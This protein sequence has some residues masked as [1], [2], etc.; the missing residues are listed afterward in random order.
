M[1]L[2]DK[3]YIVS[4]DSRGLGRYEDVRARENG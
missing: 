2:A 4:R 1:S 3:A